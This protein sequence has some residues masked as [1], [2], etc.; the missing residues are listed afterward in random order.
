[1]I[2]I[3]FKDVTKYSKRL[4]WEYSSNNAS[5]QWI[6]NFFLTKRTYLVAP[7]PTLDHC[8]GDSLTQPM[9]ITKLFKFRPES[10]R[11]PLSMVG[12]LSPMERLGGIEPG[13][14]RFYHYGLAR[15]HS[16]QLLLNFFEGNPTS[17]SNKQINSTY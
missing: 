2:S 6:F 10:Y 17:K 11:E 9:L 8:E 1:M 4:I 5:F 7:R 16:L 3:L 12:S 13:T 14:F 15:G